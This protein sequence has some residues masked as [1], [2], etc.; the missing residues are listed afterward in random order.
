MDLGVAIGAS[1]EKKLFPPRLAR[2]VGIQMPAMAL[3]TEER[4]GCIEQ[5][6]VDRT[7]WSVAVGAVFGDVAMLVCEWPLFL[8]MASC[9][10]FLLGITFEKLLLGGAMGLMAVDAGHLLFPQRVMGK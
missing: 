9:A 2:S 10:C 1:V 5:V 7:V 6:I 3:E 8:H 4:H